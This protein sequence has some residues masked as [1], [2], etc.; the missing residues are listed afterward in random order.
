MI[1]N[2]MKFAWRNIRRNK[3]R[4]GL[5]ILAIVIGMVSLVFGRSFINGMLHSMKEPIIKMQS[6]HIRLVHKE[7]LRLERVFPKDQLVAPL[8]GIEAALRDIAEIESLTRLIKFRTLAAHGEQNEACLAIGVYPEEVKRVME[9]DRFVKQGTFFSADGTGL[10]I[11]GKLAKKLGVTVGDELLLVSTD[12]NYSTYALPF[13]IAGIFEIGFSY[14]RQ[15]RGLH[16]FCQ[17]VGDDGLPRCLPGD[18]A[19]GQASR[20]GPRG[21]CADPNE[22]RRQIGPRDPGASPG[23]KTTSS[24]IPCPWSAKSMTASS[25]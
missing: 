2:I 12:I 22:N 16:R 10:I 21:R 25:T 20:A 6:G 3:R 13:R 4:T 18:P 17:S 15:K 8:S 14:L 9:L 24:R 23:R 1:R 5:T 7:Y 11:G 19:D